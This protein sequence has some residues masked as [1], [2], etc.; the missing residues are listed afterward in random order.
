MKQASEAEYWKR[1][2][3]GKDRAN[4]LYSNIMKE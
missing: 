2:Y 3:K 4:E 1:L